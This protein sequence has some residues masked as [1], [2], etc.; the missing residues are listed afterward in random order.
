[1][2]LGF[3]GDDRGEMEDN[4]RPGSDQPIRFASSR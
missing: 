4:L 3:S 1:M 2:K